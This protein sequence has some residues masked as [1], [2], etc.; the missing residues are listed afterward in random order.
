MYWRSIWRNHWDWRILYF[1]VKQFM[2]SCWMQT[3]YWLSSLGVIKKAK[4]EPK[5]SRLIITKVETYPNAYIAYE[6]TKP[7]SLYSLVDVPS[8]PFPPPP[9]NRALSTNFTLAMPLCYLWFNLCRL[10]KIHPYS[11]CPFP[12][13][14]LLE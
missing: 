1:E 6:Q 12:L 9:F 8:A 14:S 10:S 3:K 5:Q 2:L 13:I 4:E 11:C 7:L